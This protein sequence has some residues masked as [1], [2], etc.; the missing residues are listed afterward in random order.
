MVS[1]AICQLKAN[2]LASHIV[3][4]HKM[5]CKEYTEKY[6]LPTRSEKYLKGCSDRLKG[7]KNPGYQHGG[8]FSSLSDKFIYADSTDKKEIIEKITNSMK[9]SGKCSTTLKYW[10]DQGFSPE[11]AEQKLSERQTT[12]SKQICIKKYG[13][14]LGL[15]KWKDRQEKWQNTLN[16]KPPE[17][18]EEIN[19]KKLGFI[20]GFSKISQKLFKSLLPHLNGK[21]VYFANNDNKLNRKNQEFFY[22]SPEKHKFFLDFYCPETKKIIEF[23]GDYWHGEARGNQEKDRERDRVLTENGFQV[24]RVAER[25][26]K[27]DPDKVI[28]DCVEFLNG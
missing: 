5:T 9:T 16:N 17:E 8:K 20:K 12:F 11:E 6:N 2:C 21:K 23:D 26:Y 10:T 25:D 24:L 22:I 4:M 18:I 7:D 1:C 15:E 14:E 27:K 13:A 28:R 19:R 3:R